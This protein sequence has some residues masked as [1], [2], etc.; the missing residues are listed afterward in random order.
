MAASK[1]I[2]QKEH[3][4]INNLLNFVEFLLVPSDTVI[5]IQN[6]STDLCKKQINK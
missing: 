1:I 3:N 5:F 6:F 4:K 2:A